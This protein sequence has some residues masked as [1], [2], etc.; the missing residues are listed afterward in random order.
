MKTK[1]Q[2]IDRWRRSDRDCSDM[3]VVVDIAEGT[4][5]NNL[6]SMCLLLTDERK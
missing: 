1:F 4:E 6:S 5:K 2:M 3:V